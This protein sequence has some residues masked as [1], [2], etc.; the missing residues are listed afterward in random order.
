MNIHLEQEYYII[1]GQTAKD[2]IRLKPDPRN[3]KLKAGSQFITHGRPLFYT[4]A[5]NDDQR[6]DGLN[7]YGEKE[8]ITN[9]MFKGKSFILD[10][11][12]RNLLIKFDVKSVQ[13]YQAIYIDKIGNYHENYWF[14]NV[15]ESYDWCDIDRSTLDE[16]ADEDIADGDLPRADKIALDFHKMLQVPEEKRL[17]FKISNIINNYIYVHEKIKNLLEPLVGDKAKF[18]RVDEYE[19]GME[20]MDD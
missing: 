12:L 18:Y 2:V 5:Y 10:D 4:N 17:I 19:E 13:Y 11:E 8:N 1:C 3:K 9:I 15:Y 20:F 14:V 7:R 16:F 6:S